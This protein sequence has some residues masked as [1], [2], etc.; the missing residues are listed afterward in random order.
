MW[1]L[2]NIIV[3]NERK[4]S[5]VFFQMTLFF[6][7]SFSHFRPNFDRWNHEFS[8]IG[9]KI[10]LVKNV[11][12]SRGF[13][14]S[15]NIYVV[16]SKKLLKIK[17]T[18]VEIRKNVEKC[19]IFSLAYRLIFYFNTFFKTHFVAEKWRKLSKSHKNVKIFWLSWL[20]FLSKCS[21]FYVN[22]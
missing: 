11:E 19:T 2:K 9:F 17:N 22:I 1:K 12:T 3:L 20:V 13:K 4:C 21:L 18:P 16:V 10:S 15:E 7:H 5:I 14:I 8:V 6:N